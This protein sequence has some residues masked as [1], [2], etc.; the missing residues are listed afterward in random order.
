MQ[1]EVRSEWLLPSGWSTIDHCRYAD[2]K[3]KR[4]AIVPPPISNS[5]FFV[6]IVGKMGRG[7]V[8]NRQLV[9]FYLINVHLLDDKKALFIYLAS[10]QE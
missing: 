5:P 7:Y 8:L 10:F 9:F 3:E 2:T 4:S 6:V 1:R